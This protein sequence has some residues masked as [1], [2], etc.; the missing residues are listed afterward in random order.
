MKKQLMALSCLILSAVIVTACDK[1]EEAEQKTQVAPSETLAQAKPEA[2]KKADTLS[3]EEAKELLAQAEEILNGEALDEDD[4]KKAFDLAYKAADLGNLPEAQFLVGKLY[5]EGKGVELDYKKSYMFL[6]LSNIYKVEGSRTL[7]N[8]NYR[9]LQPQERKE[10]S[11]M[12]KRF[13]TLHAN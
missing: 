5:F 6:T 9:K 11:A 8:Q 2:A 13:I 1:A 10:V 4:Y 3:A 12:V 7:M